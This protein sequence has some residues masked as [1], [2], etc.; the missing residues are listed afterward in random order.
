MRSI[1]KAMNSRAW[2]LVQDRLRTWTS[3]PDRVHAGDELG[4]E[5]LFE[6]LI[7]SG[8]A[9]QAS[10]SSRPASGSE[11]RFSHLWEMQALGRREAPVPHG[12]KVGVGTIAAAALYERVLVRDMRHLD[13]DALCNDWPSR[14]EV[15]QTVLKAHDIPQIAEQAVGESLAKYI[16]ADRLRQRLDQV[17]ERWPSI[18]ERLESQLKTADQL[19]E[20]LQAAGCPTHPEQIGVSLS[21]LKESYGLARSIRSRYTVL[22][23]VHEYGDSLGVRR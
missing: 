11:H 20:L 10:R 12:F 2:S 21:Q 16:D 19:C 23:F 9:M 4:I 8:L 5:S 6:G 18:R 22:D 15:Q 7:M 13:I 3:H 14:L 17:R 1:L